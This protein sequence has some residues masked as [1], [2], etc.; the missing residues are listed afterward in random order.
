MVVVVLLGIDMCVGLWSHALQ[1][2]LLRPITAVTWFS[3]AAVAI[4]REAAGS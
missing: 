1:G 2:Y 3:P 4:S